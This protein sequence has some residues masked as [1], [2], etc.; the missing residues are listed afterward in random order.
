[1]GGRDR[2]RAGF[3]ELGEDDEIKRPHRPSPGKVAS[4]SL[5]GNPDPPRYPVS[6]GKRTLTMRLDGP[7]RRAAQ[8]PVEAHGA[9]EWPDESEHDENRVAPIQRKATGESQPD[10]RWVQ[11]RGRRG[12]GAGY[13][14][15]IPF[16]D[17]IQ[18]SFGRHDVG[19]IEAHVGGDAAA[20]ASDIGARAYATGNQV[21]FAAPPDLHT[22]AHEAAHVV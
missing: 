8:L 3:G 12:V 2:W 1:M 6:P 7:H 18:A 14:S 9:R 16:F 22:A 5:I 20:A 21:A 13:G 17:Q 10:D 15:P 19:K 4:T 11:E